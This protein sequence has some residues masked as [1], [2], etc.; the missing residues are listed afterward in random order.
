MMVV[1]L[2]VVMMKVPMLLL[3]PLERGQGVRWKKKEGEGM[4]VP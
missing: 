2:V 4:A 3:V 1:V